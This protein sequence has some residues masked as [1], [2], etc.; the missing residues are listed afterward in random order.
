MSDDELPS[1]AYKTADG[2]CLI[3]TDRDEYFQ[4]VCKVLNL[5]DVKSD[6]RFATQELRESPQYDDN[7]KLENVVGEN[8]RAL[9]AILQERV[10][11]ENGKKLANAIDKAGGIADFW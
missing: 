6:P 11:G 9:N 5:L 3:N 2:T 10:S 4:A 1:I 7:G 8:F